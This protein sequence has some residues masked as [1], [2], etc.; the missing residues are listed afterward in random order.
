[1]IT[2]LQAIGGYRSEGSVLRR[3]LGSVEF[4]SQLAIRNELDST[5]G[6]GLPRLGRGQHGQ[7][8]LARLAQPRGDGPQVIIDVA[9]MTD[10]FP[11]TLRHSLSDRMK[12]SGV[13]TASHHNSKSAVRGTQ[14]GSSHG[15]SKMSSQAAQRLRLRISLPESL[16]GTNE[17]DCD[18][19]EGIAY[20][21]Y[22]AGS[23]RAQHTF[24]H[25]RK[26]VRVFM[27]V[28]VRY[29]NTMGLEL[30]NLRGCLRLDLVRIE[31]SRKRARRETHKA[32]AKALRVVRSHQAGKTVGIDQG[33]AVQQH[34]MAANA[35]EGAELR[36]LHRI[37]KGRPIGHQ[38]CGCDEATV[39]RLGNGSIDATRE[40]KVVGVDDQSAHAK[41][42]AGHE[43]RET[44][45]STF[46]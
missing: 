38:R 46:A 20:C 28:D 40:S 35:P 12:E 11:A 9:W 24:E 19:V 45:S 18:H 14:S 36:Q 30:A 43:R 37:T 31:L 4:S 32:I 13:K 34:N 8:L 22:T 26:C 16:L 2:R 10:E 27:G 21:I 1:M 15:L 5:F 33:L 29:S 39:V 42:L 44:H 25:Y 23:R 17:I 41:S 7:F 6:K 3:R